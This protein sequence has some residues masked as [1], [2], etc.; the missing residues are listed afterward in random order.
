MSKILGYA[1]KTILLGLTILVLSCSDK[2]KKYYDSGELKEIQ[3]HKKVE[4]DTVRHGEWRRFHKNGQIATS[5]FYE[6]GDKVGDWKKFDEQGNLKE[7]AIYLYS[8]RHEETITYNKNLRS[9]KI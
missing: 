4:P 8:Q 5:E 7:K 9:N 1:K 3:S 6:D 2:A